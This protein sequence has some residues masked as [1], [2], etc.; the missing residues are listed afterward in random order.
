MSDFVHLHVHTE[1]SLL[2][3]INR[4]DT[5]PKHAKK[6]GMPA[7]AITDHGNLSGA[8]KFWKSCREAEI[9]PI[10]GLEAYYAIGDRR[11]AEK[12]DLGESYYHVVLLAENNEG[13][14]NLFHLSSLAY[15]EG[16]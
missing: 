7:V 5:L 9:K 14:H 4:I 1:M 12:D 6:L 2:D 10:I 8:Y 11:V 16:E 13:L 15:S 3:G